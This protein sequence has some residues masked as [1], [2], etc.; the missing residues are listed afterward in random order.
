MGSGD[1]LAGKWSAGLFPLID[2]WG[3]RREE[4]EHPRRAE[5]LQ[6]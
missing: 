2:G 3:K 4:Q 1:W 6:G 5:R